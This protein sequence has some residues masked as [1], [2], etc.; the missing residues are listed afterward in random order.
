ML[1]DTTTKRILTKTDLT[2]L[3]AALTGSFGII[4]IDM[5]VKCVGVATA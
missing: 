3:K 2:S 5:T 4:E 1:V